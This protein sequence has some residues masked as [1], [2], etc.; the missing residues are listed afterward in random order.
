[1]LLNCPILPLHS[2]RVVISPPAVLS[3]CLTL[4][5]CVSGKQSRLLP[6]KECYPHNDYLICLHLSNSVSSHPDSHKYQIILNNA[7]HN[8]K[9]YRA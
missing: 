1:M 3:W 6:L 5:S 7:K 9:L 8:Q 4:F 2:W